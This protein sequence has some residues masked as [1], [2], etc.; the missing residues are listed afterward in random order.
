MHFLS[1]CLYFVS[2][3][4]QTG[5]KPYPADA[6]P[7]P[8]NEEELNEIGWSSAAD[9]G[10]D[11]AAAN[12]YVP[13][14]QKQAAPAG[15]SLWDRAKGVVAQMRP[16]DEKVAASNFGYKQ[17]TAQAK[18]TP[19]YEE[20]SD[21]NF[22]STVTQGSWVVYDGNKV[23]RFKSRTN[24]KAYAEKNGG[25]V[26]SS[27]FYADNIQGKQGVAEGLDPNKRARLNDLIDQYRGATDP[28][29]YYNLDDDDYPTAYEII[30]QIEQ[31]FGDRIANKV[32]AGAEKM[33]FGR[34]THSMDSDWYDIHNKTPRVTKTGKVN[35]QDV[36]ALKR[37]LKTRSGEFTK[38]N[39]PESGVAEDMSRAAKGHEKYGKEGMQALAKAGREG[40]SEKKLDTIRDKYDNYSDDLSEQSEGLWANIHAKQNRI[41]NGSGERMRKPGSKG[42]P[43]KAAFKKAAK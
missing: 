21:T 13:P 33:H 1:A 38:P 22:G 36:N 37:N 42:A 28:E 11:F 7:M 6:R 35:T 23:K 39:L 19:M 2:D 4:D 41:K 10:S 27:E 30:A 25:K 16:F 3:R 18:Q 12:K 24:A 14:A 34:E 26:A 15:P 9:Y 8:T 17:Q 32:Q 29:A 31:E 5:F 40:A 20:G 43:T